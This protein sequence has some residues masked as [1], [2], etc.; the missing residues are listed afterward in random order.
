MVKADRVRYQ[1]TPADGEELDALERHV[2]A[3]RDAL[4]LLA[5]AEKRGFPRARATLLRARINRALP[6]ARLADIETRIRAW[7]RARDIGRSV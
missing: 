5:L 3:V 7:L 4:R 1:L 6:P 2:N